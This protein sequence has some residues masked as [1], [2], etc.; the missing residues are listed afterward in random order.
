MYRIRGLALGLALCMAGLAQGQEVTAERPAPGTTE[1]RRVSQILGSTVQ[2]N[3]GSGYGRIE[4]IVIGPDNQVEY[5]VVSHDN[6]YVALPWVV[7]QFN[8]GQRT[9]VYDVAPTAI[10][11][12]LF[13]RN[14]W[15]NFADPV[16]TR[17]F[18]TVFP[19]M[20]RRESQQIERR[21]LRPVPTTP[22]GAEV[23][24]PKATGE[25]KPKATGEVKRKKE[26]SKRP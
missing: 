16:Y 24:P 2:L 3:D 17:R 13:P 9:V 1:M 4:D 14:T 7:G 20:T 25:V 6:Q 19:A 18:Q 21:S 5:L 23:V 12:L 15:P 10:Q 22:P 11:P 26:E 8:P